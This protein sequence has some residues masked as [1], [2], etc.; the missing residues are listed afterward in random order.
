MMSK[1]ALYLLYFCIYSLVLM[2]IG[3]NSLRAGRSMRDYFICGRS[4]SVICL[5]FICL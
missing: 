2:I 4:V 5:S 1:T 3:K